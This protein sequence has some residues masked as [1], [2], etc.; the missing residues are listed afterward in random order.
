M[1]TR[2]EFLKKSAL[3][4]SC[5]SL[6]PGPGFSTPLPG[7]SP[8]ETVLHE[9]R[10]YE[11]LE[12]GQVICRLCP[13]EC[14]VAD[15]E[16]GYC[17]VRENR[18]GIYYTL[19]HSNICAAHVDPVEKKPIYH[20]LPG[21]KAYSIATAGCNIECKFCQNWEISQFR[22]EQIPSKSLT[23]KEVVS[24]AEGYGCRSIAY[25]YTEPVVFY[26]YMYDCAQAGR[27]RGIKSVMI[28]NGYIQEKP[29]RDLLPVLDAVKIDLKAFTESFYRSMCS[30][31]LKPVLKTLEVLKESGIW[32]EIVVLIIPFRNDSREEI[33]S[34]CRWIVDHL[35]PHIPVHFT[36]FHPTY[37]IK[38]LP[39]TP[40]KTLEDAYDIAVKSGLSFA[41]IGNVPGH[42]GEYTRC[43]GCHEVLV[44][45]QGFWISETAI[46]AGCCIHCGK[47]V[48]GIWN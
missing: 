11:K 42:A 19:V 7:S 20:F 45:R 33:E 31:A 8:R 1:P 44:R 17:G 46:K 14:Q 10:Y 2:R 13:R 5:C 37:K 23:P 27:A 47:K 25:T 15:K 3:A 35:G 30:G 24:T 6:F 9:A 40:L 48:P 34:M 32:F 18:E 21:T 43:P 38:D 29:L 4:C 26:E 36:R 12:G 22:P 39:R 28:S 41:Y 16:R